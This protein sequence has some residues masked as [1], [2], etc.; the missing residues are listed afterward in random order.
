M[1]TMSFPAPPVPTFAPEH[2]VTAPGY[3]R[4]ED[5]TQDGRLMPLGVP[6][7]LGPLWQ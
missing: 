4:Y 3:L 5:C 7:S 6:P 2:A 1:P